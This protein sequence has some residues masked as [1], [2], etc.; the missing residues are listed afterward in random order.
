MGCPPAEK[1]GKHAETQ[2]EYV[3]AQMAQAIQPMNASI[4]AARS[5]KVNLDLE[6]QIPLGQMLS[7]SR[8]GPIFPLVLSPEAEMHSEK[9]TPAM[10]G[11]MMQAAVVKYSSADIEVLQSDSDKLA[12]FIEVLPGPSA[13][14]ILVTV[15]CAMMSHSSRASFW[16]WT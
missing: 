7:K 11:F 15:S 16:S 14:R 6:L 4:S 9:I 12:R 13:L 5:L 10:I 2:L 3:R 8:G 1:E